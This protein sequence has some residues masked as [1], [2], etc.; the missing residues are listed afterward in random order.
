MKAVYGLMVL[1]SMGVSMLFAQEGTVMN[2]SGKVT[3]AQGGAVRLLEKED[4]VTVGT[5]IE[6]GADGN[7]G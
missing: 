3:I 5:R 2:V 6:T 7:R 4:Q 1:A